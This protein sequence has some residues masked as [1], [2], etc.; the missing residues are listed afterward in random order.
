M[1][2]L[3]DG[4]ETSILRNILD[5]ER[6]SLLHIQAHIRRLK[7]AIRSR[8]RGHPDDTVPKVEAERGAKG[9]HITYAIPANPAKR[10]TPPCHHLPRAQWCDRNGPGGF[11]GHTCYKRKPTKGKTK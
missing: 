7:A 5:A 10:K 4:I 6:R 3:Y 9:P 11:M 8:R 1:S 2:H